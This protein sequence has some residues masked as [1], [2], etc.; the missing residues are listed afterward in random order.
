MFSTHTIVGLSGFCRSCYPNQMAYG[1][2]PKKQ[3]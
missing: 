3:P 1:G 2:K